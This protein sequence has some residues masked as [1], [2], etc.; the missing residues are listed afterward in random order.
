MRTWGGYFGPGAE[1]AGPRLGERMPKDEF[2]DVRN[3]RHMVSSAIKV[4]SVVAEDI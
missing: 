2:L 3:K 4:G 1:S